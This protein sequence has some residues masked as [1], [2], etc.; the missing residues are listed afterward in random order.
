MAISKD[1]IKKLVIARLETMPPTMKISLGSM[2]VFSK[3]ELIGEVRQG[4]KIGEK[5]IEI[6]LS[7]LRS[8][9]K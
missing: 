5:I 3:E 7:Y 1:E 4:S 9:S 6:Q 2:G 8:F